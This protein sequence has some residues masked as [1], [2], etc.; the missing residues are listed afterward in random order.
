MTEKRVMI[1]RM[2]FAC[3]PAKTDEEALEMVKNFNEG[4]FDWESVRCCTDD[5]E[6][7]ETLEDGVTVPPAMESK[8]A[9]PESKQNLHDSNELSGGYILLP[10]HA[11]LTDEEADAID[12]DDEMPLM[13]AAISRES[14]KRYLGENTTDEE[15][16]HWLS[17]A[18][19]EDTDDVYGFALLDDGVAF[20]WDELRDEPFEVVGI[21]SFQ[22]MQAAMDFIS[23]KM[24][25]SGYGDASMWLDS[26]FDL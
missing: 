15:L 14:L 1:Q 2:G 5:A 12:G 24:Q 22:A 25:E 17:D 26:L 20:T 23:G 8:P 21:D 11:E 18:N 9:V 6:I 16:E 7:I 19:S 10:V 3:V 4:D 13:Y